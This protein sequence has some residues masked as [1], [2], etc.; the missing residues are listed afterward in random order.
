MAES[1]GRCRG[2]ILFELH[3]SGGFGYDPLFWVPGEGCTA[4]QLPADVKNR[5][6]HRGQALNALLRQLPGEFSPSMA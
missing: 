6:S 2:R 4:A 3:G 5:L 1:E